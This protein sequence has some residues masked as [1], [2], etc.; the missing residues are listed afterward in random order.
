MLTVHVRFSE[1]CTPEN[2]KQETLSTTS[3]L[4]VRGGEVLTVSPEAE[5]E[6]FSVHHLDK[7]H[8]PSL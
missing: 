6:L 2:L 7:L 1:M 3:P 5:D 4:M 8:T